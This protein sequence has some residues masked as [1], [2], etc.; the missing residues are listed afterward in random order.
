MREHGYAREGETESGN[1]WRHSNIVSTSNIAI[2]IASGS[3]G[4]AVAIVGTTVLT[5]ESVMLGPGRLGSALPTLVS[6]HPS[7]DR[8]RRYSSP[9]FNIG[10]FDNHARLNGPAACPAILGSQ[11]PFPVGFGQPFNRDNTDPCLI[12]TAVPRA[13][14]YPPSGPELHIA[15]LVRLHTISGIHGVSTVN[16]FDKGMALVDIDNTCL[17][18]TVFVKERSQVSFR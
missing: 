12:I 14:A 4:T 10:L 11:H 3:T 15:R 17:H 5:A 13:E 6:G 8:F 2:R 9:D 1:S 16:H 18:H 7:A